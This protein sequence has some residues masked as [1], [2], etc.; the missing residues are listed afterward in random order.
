[1]PQPGKSGLLL[2]LCAILDAAIA[3]LYLSM[4]GA[5]GPL[6]FHNWGRAVVL[7]GGLT[8]LAGACSIVAAK[9]WP[10]RLHGVALGG[11]G[12]IYCFFANHFPVGILT[13]ALLAVLASLSAALLDLDVARTMRRRAPAVLIGS[14]GIVSFAFAASFLALG[15]RW[16][17]LGPGSHIDLKLLGFYF[18]VTAAAMIGLSAFPHG[19]EDSRAGRIRRFTPP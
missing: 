8:L 13:V 19:M 7:L 17:H 18:A 14:A 5:N 11:L 9:A 10:L 15:L 16:L 4:S 2:A 1:M 12:I 6:F 3:L